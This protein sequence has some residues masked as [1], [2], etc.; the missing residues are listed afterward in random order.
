MTIVIV[1]TIVVY[2]YLSI[3]ACENLTIAHLYFIFDCILENQPY[4]HKYQNPGLPVVESHTHALSR[5]TKCVR[6]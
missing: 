3:V 4:G 6:T 2:H 5:D 1:L